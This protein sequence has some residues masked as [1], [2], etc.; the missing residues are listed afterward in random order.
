MRRPR[1]HSTTAG[2]WLGYAIALASLV[3]IVW[4]FPFFFM[5]SLY[6]AR[7]A[8][9]TA[10][11][12]PMLPPVIT[13]VLVWVL[14]VFNLIDSGMPK[15]PPVFQFCSLLGGPLSVTVVSL[16]ELHRMRTRFGVVLRG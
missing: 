8:F 13:G 7:S 16:W 4:G 3:V 1:A 10:H 2:D 9:N 14:A 11:V 12:H 6:S 15:D 5:A